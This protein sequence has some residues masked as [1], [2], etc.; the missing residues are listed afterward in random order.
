MRRL[1]A[2][3]SG[4]LLASS[5]A[6]SSRRV[7]LMLPLAAPPQ[8]TAPS[9]RSPL[10]AA[11]TAAAAFFTPQPPPPRVFTTRDVGDDAVLRSR[12]PSLP[13]LHSDGA[14]ASAAAVA[15]GLLD[16]LTRLATATG[17]EGLGLAAPQL[18]WAAPAFVL[19]APADADSVLADA[20]CGAAADAASLALLAGPANAV[21]TAA[22]AGQWRL[23]VNPRVLEPGHSVA[24]GFEA[25]FSV[26][27]RVAVVPRARAGVVVA[28]ETLR[29]VA[30][31]A[32]ASAVWVEV[33]EAVAAL[34]GLPA[35]VFQ[36]EADHCAGIL[37]D[38]AAGARWAQDVPDAELASL[39][40]AWND[41]MARWY[42]ARAQHEGGQRGRSRHVSSGRA[43]RIGDSS[44][45]RH[46]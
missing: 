44:A 35:V 40:R 36:H 6:P 27:G 37:L 13:L 17:D 39:E 42:G 32:T 4:A 5:S 28:F 20:A 22:V 24:A 45:Q 1:P 9:P 46:E 3:A 34:D 11:A 19:R 23:I 31:P 21:V 2:A 7:R 38:T 10:A 33:V 41:G 16:G 18:G 15:A 12:A 25:C 8:P 26:P 30:E 43:R 29:A 14:I